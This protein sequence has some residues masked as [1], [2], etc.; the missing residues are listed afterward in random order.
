MTRAPGVGEGVIVRS[1][2][3]E[4]GQGRENLLHKNALARQNA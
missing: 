3:A 1:W 4:E 2:T